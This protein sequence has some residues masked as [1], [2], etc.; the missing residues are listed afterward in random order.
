MGSD[1]DSF[2]DDVADEVLM[3]LEKPA[4]IGSHARQQQQK[5]V[6]SN[7]ISHNATELE[8]EDL[9]SDAFDYSPERE[10]ERP[11]QPV[12]NQVRNFQ[13]TTLLGRIANQAP[14]PL[15]TQPRNARVFRAD[16]P[17][18][19]PTHH[20]LDPEALKTWVYPTNLGPIRD[21][22]FSIVKNGLFNNTLVALPTGLGKTFIAATVILNF[23]RWTRN[24]QMVFVAPTKPLASQQVEAC[25][26]IAGIPRSQSTL[27][28]GE[29]KPVLREAE[30]EGKR[31]FFMTPQTL[32][33]DLS[34]G[35]AD[36]KRIVLLVVDEAHR[37]TGDYA[38][39]K[40][41]EFIR[42]FSKSFRVLALTATP[43]S[44]V[45]GVQDV[46]DNLGV[47]HVEIRTEESID[48]R[49]YVHSREIDRIV[50]EPSD[51]MLR[52]S[53]LFSQALKPLHSKISQ[54]NIYI[55]RDPMS[56]TTFG[57]LKARQDWMKGPGRFANQG[58][59]MMLM[60]I[61]TILQSLAHAI[62]LLNYHGIR[63]F[64]DNLVAFRAETEDK[65][66]KGSKY[67]RQLI[68]EPSFQEMMDLASKWLKIDGFAGHPKLTHLCD[69]LLNH[70]MDAGEG[71][72]TRVIVFSEYRDS[73]EEITRVLNV[74]KPMISASL[75]VGQ[76]DSKKS[77]GMKQK[78]Q[79]ETIAKFR[80]GTFN[81]LVATS[82]GEEGLDIGQVDL[83][84]CYDASSSPIRMLQRMGRTGRKRAGKITLL[85]MKGKE[86]ENYAKAQDNYEK[87]QKL[88][89]EGSR[90]NFRHDL[91]SRIVPRDVKPEV[92]KRM[93]EIPIENT[94]DTSLP[95]P[96]ARSTRGKKASKKKFNMPDGVETG[97]NSV[98]SMLGISTSKA[99]PTKSPKKVE[100]KETDEISPIPPL[101]RVLLSAKELAE[102][103][104]KYR[105]LPFFHQATEEI[106]MPSLTAHPDLQRV[107]RPTVHIKHGSYTKRCVRLFK[108]LSNSQGIETR[109][110]K[111]HGHTD[112]SRYLDIPVP[113]FAEESGDDVTVVSSGRK[114]SLSPSFA[115]SPPLPGRKR[116]ADAAAAPRSKRQSVVDEYA[117]ESED[118]APPARQR[119]TS[120]AADSRSKRQSVVDEYA[121]ESEADAITRDSEDEESLGSLA[122]FI[123]DGEVNDNF[124]KDMAGFTSDED[125]DYR[126]GTL[127]KS[128][129]SGPLPGRQVH[130]SSGVASQSGSAAP[131]AIEPFFVPASLPGTQQTDD[132]EDMPDIG[133]LVGKKQ[134]ETRV[135]KPAKK[136][137][138]VFLSS[139]NDDDDNDDEDNVQAGPAKRTVRRR[140]IEDSE[141]D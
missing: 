46:I 129:S 85:L 39:V 84:I 126:S 106:S 68:G 127:A 141:S 140:V 24:A 60:A 4:T 100:P 115:A 45:E 51:E 48:I 135:R 11:T 42:R 50:L 20:E 119:R 114:R 25:L 133:V 111:P 21:Y 121:S 37:A 56:I 98:A 30:W 5:R 41:I 69:N 77:E 102:L 38:Y 31:L 87:M 112:T 78:Q 18:E 29:T 63:P 44:T 95:E 64:Y 59:K 10:R 57:L 118:D 107:L 73:A 96:K 139:D 116:K 79:I 134:L 99:Q 113:P 17:P 53:E 28:T 123:S 23:F 55:G 36:P 52:I 16:L 132:D 1:Y 92:D 9:D 35:Y 49:N 128:S 136:S 40:V 12:R 27:L 72:S 26:N 137:R 75:F 130:R 13:Q 65:G 54:Q 62:K 120:A 117:S 97:F 124:P 32:M 122:D 43:G 6:I 81:V 15:G 34:K 14:E 83:I 66:Q 61:F 131:A 2:D 80:D 108:K 74:H 105:D 89:C 71:S 86:E 101:E 103:N 110:T 82:I 125:D 138:A 67:K 94:Q 104:K 88:I 91:S 8:L 90:F 33:N 7:A 47:S 22:Q 93:V 70:F 76:A 109:H 19:V 58:L 3:A